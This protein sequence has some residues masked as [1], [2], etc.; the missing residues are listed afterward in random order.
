MSYNSILGNKAYLPG[1]SW[2]C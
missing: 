2:I 1:L